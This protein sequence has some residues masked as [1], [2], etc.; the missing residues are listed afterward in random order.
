MFSKLNKYAKRII[1]AGIIILFPF[2]LFGQQNKKSRVLFLLDASSSMTYKWND[3][4]TR[5][6]IAS[7]ILLRI[8]DSI[9]SLNP[10]VEFALRAYGTQYP[11]IEKN[12]SDTRLEVPFNIQNGYQIKTKL[13]NIS[14]IG[15]SPIAYSLRQAADNELDDANRYDYSI[16]F[17]TDG[18]ESCNG[19]VCAT[20]K[21]FLKKKIKVT[22]Y[23]IGLD[24]NEQLNLLYECMGNYIKVAEPDD[25]NLAIKTIVNANRPLV[26]KPLSL[27]IKPAYTNTPAIKNEPSNETNPKPQPVINKK[28]LTRLYAHAYN[29]LKQT[30]QIK[31]YEKYL[32]LKPVVL[33]FNFE[34]NKK[35]ETKEHTIQRI[36]KELNRLK[37]IQYKYSPNN[38]KTVLTGHFIV[39]NKQTA[40]I[41]F[42][43]DTP[44]V[45]KISHV[46][47][48]MIH[49]PYLVKSN[50]NEI[51]IQ[52]KPKT[53]NKKE[54]ATI[55]FEYETPITRK[56]DIFKKLITQKYPYKQEV[57]LFTN[58][59]PIAYKNKQT[60]VL[61]FENYDEKKKYS[62]ALIRAQAYPKR[63]AYAIRIPQPKSA[64]T[65]LGT[66]LFRYNTEQ[67]PT[68][69]PIAKPKDTLTKKVTPPTTNNEITEFTTS[70]ENNNEK[71]EVQV[72]FEGK[73]GKKYPN[74]TP[75]IIFKDLNAQ[76]TTTSFIRKVN[77]GVPIPQSIKEGKYDVVV[78]GYNDLFVK[79]VTI[80]PNKLNKVVIKVTEGTLSFAYLGN[81]SRPMEYKAV[82]NRRFSNAPDVLQSCTQRL[83]YEP[84][85]YY[86]EINTLPASKFSIDMSFGALY[87]LQIPEPG[88]LQITNKTAYGNI[89]LQY[90]HGDKFETFYNMKIVGS[91]NLQK[92]EILPGRY[93]IILP[94]NPQM[95][96][97][98]TK[99]IDFRINSNQ[100]TE[101]ELQ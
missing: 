52:S 79:N 65:N 12:C 42:D 33:N 10:E 54:I 57:I 76:G 11:A 61:K 1:V 74:A 94:V 15:F 20:F 95:P 49:I 37:N 100:V 19:D 98:G 9:Y 26:D 80:V 22:P 24:K 73:T 41:H 6:D 70:T 87:E 86:V 101:V 27:N 31:G 2:F 8:V 67:T 44:P 43:T 62:L 21:D 60:A 14:P 50:K 81:R 56:N 85:T 90:E 91:P 93:K 25:I 18:G 63:V 99:V 88:Y 47:P 39:N 55:K 16:I 64:P 7:N 58:P 97:M 46:F 68:P 96:Q 4:Y 59:K 17:I 34:E 66:A 71:T 53:I 69:K 3:N 75:E 35:I 82:V 40:I 38:N 30:L 29:Y 89:F 36:A 84:G 48:R 77:A 23:I 83:P 28:S 72:F 5:F 45:K 32:P 78:K 51:K 13:K 92:I